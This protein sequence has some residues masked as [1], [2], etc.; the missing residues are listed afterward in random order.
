[1]IGKLYSNNKHG[2]DIL[3]FGYTIYFNFDNTLPDIVKNILDATKNKS[4]YL[5]GIDYIEIGPKKDY[6]T[7]W[8]TNI[9][10]ILNRIGINNISRIEKSW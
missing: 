9:I 1:M 4:D 3:E 8:S 2:N 10:E 7:S 5:D 6:S